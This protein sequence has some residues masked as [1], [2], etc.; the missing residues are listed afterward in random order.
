MDLLPPF[1]RSKVSRA[2][3][4]TVDDVSVLELPGDAGEY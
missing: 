1:K 3:M 4:Q 2:S